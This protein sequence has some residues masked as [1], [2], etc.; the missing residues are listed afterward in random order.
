MTAIV[1]L[2]PAIDLRGGRVVRLTK[3]DY[4]AETVYGDDPRLRNNFIRQDGVSSVRVDRGCV[5]TLYEHDGFR[6]RSTTLR[7]DNPDLRSTWVGN[8]SVSSLEVSC[9][10]R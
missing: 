4:D 6:G 8:D 2:Y 9:R 5:V 10:R 7:R 3:G 1:D